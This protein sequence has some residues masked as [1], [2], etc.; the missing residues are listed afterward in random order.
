MESSASSL[1]L[2][3]LINE[4][5]RGSDGAGVASVGVGGTDASVLWRR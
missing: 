1:P 4:D 2:S 3:T 5:V